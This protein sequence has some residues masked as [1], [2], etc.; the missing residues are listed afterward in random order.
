[1]P[2]RAPVWSPHTIGSPR[3]YPAISPERLTAAERGYGGKKW[4]AL[5]RATFLRDDYL[6]RGCG[7]VCVGKEDGGTPDQWPHA[8]HIVPK[9]KGKDELSNLQTLCG[10]CH[11]S[12][13][14]RERKAARG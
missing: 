9:P 2:N 6:C 10:S 12:K 11:S 5:R 3:S 14:G 1:M 4:E 8:D 7:R 13:T